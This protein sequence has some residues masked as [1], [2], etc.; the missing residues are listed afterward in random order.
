M[1]KNMRMRLEGEP[2]AEGEL[3]VQG[4]LSAG[5]NVSKEILFY[6]AGSM[7]SL[8]TKLGGRSRPL[9]SLKDKGNV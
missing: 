6:Y 7:W 8:H 3:S 9:F 2:S 4:E 5:G 1:R